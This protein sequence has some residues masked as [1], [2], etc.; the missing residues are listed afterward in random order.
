MLV[1]HKSRVAWNGLLNVNLCAAVRL[2]DVGC[3]MLAVDAPTVPA[4]VTMVLV[5]I[6]RF[7]TNQSRHACV[8]AMPE[9][10]ERRECGS[11]TLL[12]MDTRKQR[13][14]AW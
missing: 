14:S 3:G 4:A 6:H 5:S 13:S 8:V 2:N 7:G 9:D 12:A 10:R 11:M 1:K